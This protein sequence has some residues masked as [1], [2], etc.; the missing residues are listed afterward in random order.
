MNKSSFNTVVNWRKSQ[1]FIKLFETQRIISQHLIK[2]D[3]QILGAFH[4]GNVGD[5]TLGL[6][7]ANI[8]KSEKPKIGLQNIYN[9]RVYPVSELTICAGGATGVNSNMTLLAERN[10]N[11]A[12]KTSLIGMDFASDIGDFSDNALEFLSNVQYISCR[13]RKQTEKVA[14]VLNRGDI[15]YQP[16]NAFAYDFSYSKSFKEKNTKILGFNS[17]P[18]FMQWI[19]KKGFLPGTAL[20]SWYKN[21]N[22]NFFQYIEDF[23]PKYIEYIQNCLSIYISRGWQIHHVPF[24]TE[25]DTFAKT[26]FQM[27]GVK[28]I[29]FN[30][31]PNKTFA[32][33]SN[34]D[35]F[36]ST[37]YH[38]LVFSLIARVPCIPFMYAVKCND[39]LSD[40]DF[41]SNL[42][43]AI[44]RLE[45][46]HSFTQAV[47]KTVHP[48]PYLLDTKKLQLIAN[49]VSN[50]IYQAVKSIQI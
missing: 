32:H 26:F 12:A 47:E 30:P 2:P 6:S 15:H 50:N 44:D 11:M 14:S 8:A 29:S 4:G 36:L 17:L 28:F 23:G 34:C 46:I 43:H 7:V 22:N 13:S 38:S 33:V 41:D 9:L 35:L 3:L 48:D 39:L 25:D 20:A 19:N 16:D 31:S 40:L 49:E 42:N 37:R 10:R 21:K 45:I 1:V 18:F 24:T 27:D 5:N